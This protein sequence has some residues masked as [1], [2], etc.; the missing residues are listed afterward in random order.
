MTLNVASGGDVLDPGDSEL[1]FPN[2]HIGRVSDVHFTILHV[3]LMPSSEGERH[4]THSCALP[5]C[6]T[7]QVMQGGK[8]KVHI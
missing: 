8:T 1:S 5:P 7:D 2:T 3:M 4:N 6:H